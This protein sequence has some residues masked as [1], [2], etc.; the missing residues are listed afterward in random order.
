MDN[1]GLS[2]PMLLEYS[3]P[4]IMPGICTYFVSEEVSKPYAVLDD[5][6]NSS[7]VPNVVVVMLY[8]TPV[9]C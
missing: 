3:D 1:E 4:I 2:V 6:E 7:N 9:N 8:N 5:L